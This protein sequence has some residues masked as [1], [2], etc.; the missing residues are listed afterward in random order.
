LRGAA[1]QWIETPK[2]PTLTQGNGELISEQL[3]DSAHEWRDVLLGRVEP[4]GSSFPLPL[5]W[6]RQVQLDS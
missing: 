1:D 4:G 6:R 2:R 3:W 5:V